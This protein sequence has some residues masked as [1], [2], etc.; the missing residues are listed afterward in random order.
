MK[1]KAEWSVISAAFDAIVQLPESRRSERLAA[2]EPGLAD[3]VAAL[4]AER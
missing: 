4:R 1:D 3:E 2:L